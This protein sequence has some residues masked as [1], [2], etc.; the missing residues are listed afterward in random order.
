MVLSGQTADSIGFGIGIGFGFGFGFGFGIGIGAL[1]TDTAQVATQ[2]N[3]LQHARWYKVSRNSGG[4]RSGVVQR[5]ARNA[6]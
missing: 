4:T 1:Q 2:Y 5:F 3:M 6:E